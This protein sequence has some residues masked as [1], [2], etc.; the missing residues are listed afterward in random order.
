VLICFVFVN[1]MKNRTANAQS[2]I[3]NGIHSEGKRPSGNSIQNAG[4]IDNFSRM[5]GIMIA[6]YLDGLAAMKMNSICQTRVTP[7]K[8]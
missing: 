1:D 6:R 2:I 3:N 5:Q 4:T 8:V 7:A